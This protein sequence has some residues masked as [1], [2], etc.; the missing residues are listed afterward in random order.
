MVV[1]AVDRLFGFTLR[2]TPLVHGHPLILD[3][4]STQNSG[5]EASLPV[6]SVSVI[7]PDTLKL[8]DHIS[9]IS[10]TLVRGKIN[11]ANLGVKPCNRPNLGALK[12][13]SVEWRPYDRPYRG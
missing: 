2:R 1:E 9:G 12:K 3:E 7:D 11:A 4:I 10:T 6:T 8:V 13:T 5:I